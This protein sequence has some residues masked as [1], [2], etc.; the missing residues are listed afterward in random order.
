[1]AGFAEEDEPA[2]ID[3]AAYPHSLSDAIH[4]PFTI[5]RLGQNEAAET[6]AS[7]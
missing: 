1:M 2:G 5:D 6:V 3:V 7:V 4:A